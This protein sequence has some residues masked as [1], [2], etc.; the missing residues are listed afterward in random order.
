[1][2]KTVSTDS[3]RLSAVAEEREGLQLSHF[4]YEFAWNLGSRIRAKAAAADLPVA[5]EI[6]HGTDVIF[7]TLVGKATIDNLDWARRKGAVAHRFHKSS[8]EVRLEA[9]ENSY[10]FNA[11]FRL[12]TT[13]YVA[14]GGGFPLIIRGGLLIGTAAV[15]GLPDV[16]DH[17]LIVEALKDMTG[18]PRDNPAD[19]STDFRY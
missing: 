6:R 8:L 15:S 19:S 2:E 5:I 9:Q 3:P 10:D 7:S 12:P 14:S 17:R 16:E 1:M 4:D 18:R 11:H 13:D